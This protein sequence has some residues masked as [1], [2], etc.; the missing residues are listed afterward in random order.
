MTSIAAPAAGDRHSIALPALVGF[1]IV[2]MT[3]GMPLN[4]PVAGRNLPLGPTDLMMLVLLVTLPAW[5]RGL[6]PLSLLTLCAGLFVLWAWTSS[7]FWSIDYRRSV[8]TAKSLLEAAI[9]FVACWHVA[10]DGR[11]TVERAIRVMNVILVAQILWIV[12]RLL[13]QAEVLGY[14]A[15]K[16]GIM[17]PLGGSNYLAVF[18]EFGLFF[19]LLARRRGWPVLVALNGAGILLTF[20]RGAL[21][22]SGMM[23]AGLTVVM[24]FMRGRRPV[25]AAVI[26]A[27]LAAA[28]VVS[29]TPALQVMLRAFEILS[30]TADSRIELWQDAW[31]AAAWR[32][33]TG[34]GYGA[35]E[36]IGTLRDAH[37]LPMALLAETGVVGLALFS[38]ALLA[39][40]GRALRFSADPLAG[41]RRPE[42]QGLAAGLMVVLLH[43]LIEPFFLG[44]SAIW[45]A[46]VFAWIAGP[47]R[48]SEP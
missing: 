40:L 46:A 32:P 8:L 2:A 20:S 15:L 36:S 41:H 26:A 9:M 28:V 5:Y 37:S 30:R 47:W 6:P 10:R 39:A 17:L 16:N 34:V 14:Y 31:Q 35:Y 33:L 22:A 1:A 23:L 42:A 45:A 7:V 38:F 13:G 19:E 11:N 21:L 44:F 4:L 12:W 43:S 48:V 3:L 25:A 18:L 29:V 24:L 27:M